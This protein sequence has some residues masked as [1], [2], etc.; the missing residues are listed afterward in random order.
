MINKA[1]CPQCGAEGK[2]IPPSKTDKKR[3][4]I[5]INFK[6]ENNHVFTVEEDIK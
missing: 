4:K 5:I 2:F 1:L 6:C 3:K